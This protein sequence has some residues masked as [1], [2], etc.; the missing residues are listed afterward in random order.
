MIPLDEIAIEG[1]RAWLREHLHAFDADRHVRLHNLLRPGSRALGDC[2]GVV[3][4][5]GRNR[6]WPTIRLSA[7]VMRR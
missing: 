1:S 3:R 2:S 5:A 6:R 7:S 4:E